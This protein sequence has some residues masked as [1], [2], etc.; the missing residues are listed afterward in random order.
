MVKINKFIYTLFKKILLEP[1]EKEILFIRRQILE[2][3]FDEA[4]ES[5]GFFR[6]RLGKNFDACQLQLR[7][8]RFFE[9]IEKKVH[10]GPFILK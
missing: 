6:K 7:K 2:G 9:L 4:Q 8:Q 3:S 5:L 10:E 1:L